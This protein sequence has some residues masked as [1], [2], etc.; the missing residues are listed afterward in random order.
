MAEESERAQVEVKCASEK[1]AKI[2]QQ[3]KVALL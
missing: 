1:E 3:E 2:Q